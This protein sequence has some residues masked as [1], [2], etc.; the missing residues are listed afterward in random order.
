MLERGTVERQLPLV[1]RLLR[2]VHRGKLERVLA[3]EHPPDG[4]LGQRHLRRRHQ[5]L[6]RGAAAVG[7]ERRGSEVLQ[8]FH[9]G[10]H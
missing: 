9:F 7:D 6:Q 5:T 1:G 3:L 4:H 2:L 10:R 8:N